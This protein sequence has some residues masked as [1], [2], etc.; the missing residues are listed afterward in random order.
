[1]AD[2]VQKLKNELT[3][4]EVLM[5]AMKTPGVKINREKFLHKELIKFRCKLLA[6]RQLR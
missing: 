6:M 4:E 5:T 3:F 2:I 1:M